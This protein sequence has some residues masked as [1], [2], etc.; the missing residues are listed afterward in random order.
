MFYAELLTPA[1]VKLNARSTGKRT[2]DEALLVVADWLK[3]GLPV[4][5]QPGYLAGVEN[6][7]NKP[8]NVVADRAGILSAIKKA[9]LEKDDAFAI[10]AALR[11]KGLIDL[12][13]VAAGK[14]NIKFVE[15]LKEFCD[16]EKVP[17]SGINLPM[18][19]VSG[20][21]TAC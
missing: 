20:G 16:Y 12:P 1:G 6:S 21:I 8:I 4:V 7:K 18:G 19:I 9:V 15:Y 2:R 5:K 17:M 14:G 3:D 10:V 13:V 11:A